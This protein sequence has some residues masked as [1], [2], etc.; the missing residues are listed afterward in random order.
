MGQLG[1]LVIML[2]DTLLGVR[3]LELYLL[4]LASM[5]IKEA[6]SRQFLEFLS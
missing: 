6:L 5:Y 3:D 2:L 1:I 4:Y